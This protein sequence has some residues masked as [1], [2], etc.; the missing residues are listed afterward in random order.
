VTELDV[1]TFC[2]A[3]VLLT[4]IVLVASF[5]PARHASRVDPTRAL[6]EE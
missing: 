1:S 4:A 3:T 6:R 5:A 2:L